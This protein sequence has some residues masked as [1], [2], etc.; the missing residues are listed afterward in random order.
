MSQLPEPVSDN[1]IND[2]FDFADKVN[3]SLDALASLQDWVVTIC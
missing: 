1:D 3:I 2:M